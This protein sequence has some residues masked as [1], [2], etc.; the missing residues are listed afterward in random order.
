[1]LSISKGKKKAQASSKSEYNNLTAQRIIE[2]AQSGDGDKEAILEFAARMA[3]T[4]NRVYTDEEK[5]DSKDMLTAVGIVPDFPA[6]ASAAFNERR[7]E[8]TLLHFF[9]KR[10]D[11]AGLLYCLI[12]GVSPNSVNMFYKEPVVVALEN[13][14]LVCAMILAVAR[15]PYPVGPYFKNA[16]PDAMSKAWKDAHEEHERDL[17]KE[18]GPEGRTT[19]FDRT[20]KLLNAFNDKVHV[21]KCSTSGCGSEDTLSIDLLCCKPGKAQELSLRCLQAHCSERAHS[22]DAL[23]NSH[24]LPLVMKRAIE[25]DIDINGNYEPLN[26]N[27]IASRVRNAFTLHGTFVARGEASLSLFYLTLMS[28]SWE[29]KRDLSFLFHLD[30]NKTVPFDYGRFK[31][32]LLLYWPLDHPVLD[33]MGITLE[34]RGKVD[35]KINNKVEKM[36]ERNISQLSIRDKEKRKGKGKVSDLFGHSNEGVRSRGV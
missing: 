10:G 23:L 9:A 4:V 11:V 19:H 6:L 28:L 35:K 16:N 12:A 14:H 5:Q 2:Y 1:M 31:N 15:G 25:T 26:S 3:E 24:L 22:Y 8:N 29:W 30:R 7:E 13:D 21:H 32:G 27:T 18:S 20:K 17:E 33:I 36:V 34:L